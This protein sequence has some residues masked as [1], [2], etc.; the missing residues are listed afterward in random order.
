M[1][2]SGGEADLCSP[3]H[4]VGRVFYGVESEPCSVSFLLSAVTRACWNRAS[5]PTEKLYT[6]WGRYS[7]RPL[8]RHHHPL[9]NNVVKDG[10]QSLPGLLSGRN[11][12]VCWEREAV[13]TSVSQLNCEGGTDSN[14]VSVICRAARSLV[15][16]V[17]DIAISVLSSVDVLEGCCGLGSQSAHVRVG[18]GASASVTVWGHPQLRVRVEVDVGN[19][20]GQGLEVVGNVRGLRGGEG[21]RTLVVLGAR[22]AG[23]STSAPLEAPVAVGISSKAATVRLGVLAVHTVGGLGDDK[24]IRVHDRNDVEGVLLQVASYTAVSAL[25]QLIDQVSKGEER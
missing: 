17:V 1:T 10:S 24:A 23:G 22:V 19:N 18:C 4:I 13:G 11:D 6:L 9:D 5:I 3:F 2:E 21:A 12:L 25:Q 8:W 7:C 20:L 14:A 16:S 15:D